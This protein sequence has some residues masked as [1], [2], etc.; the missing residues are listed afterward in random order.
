[1]VIA[2]SG[3][4]ARNAF[5]DGTGHVL[6]GAWALPGRAGLANPGAVT[7]G[8]RHA[9]ARTGKGAFRDCPRTDAYGGTYAVKSLCRGKSG[10]QSRTRVPAGYSSS[11]FSAWDERENAGRPQDG[12]AAARAK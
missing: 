1:M 4:L 5:G 10:P 12:H 9:V 8:S 11:S 2:R 7:A 6:D 3:C